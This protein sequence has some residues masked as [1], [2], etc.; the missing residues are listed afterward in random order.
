MVSTAMDYLRFCQMLLNGG[1]LD[2]V[3]VLSPTTVRLMRTNHLAPQLMP[4]NLELG[5]QP[6]SSFGLDFAIIEDP[7]ANGTAYCKGEYYW[8]GA[9]GTWFWIDPV[10]DLVFVGL[11]QQFMGQ[12]QMPDVRGISKRA[13]YSAIEECNAPS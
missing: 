4:L 8:G 11:V 13:F 2:G 3:R 9:S 6:G 7:V 5:G 12:P 1:V 10:E